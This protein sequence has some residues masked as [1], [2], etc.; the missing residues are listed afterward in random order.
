[1]IVFICSC[2]FKYIII[3]YYDCLVCLMTSFQK[4]TNTFF[5]LLFLC[6]LSRALPVVTGGG[7]TKI[8]LYF[9]RKILVVPPPPSPRGGGQLKLH[10]NGNFCVKLLRCEIA[11]SYFKHYHSCFVKIL[12]VF[13][14]CPS[15]KTISRRNL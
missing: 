15:Q 4:K 8:C 9:K 12:Q 11:V 3:Q 14:P 13:Y 1:M 2:E 10:K 5:G 7:T 6:G